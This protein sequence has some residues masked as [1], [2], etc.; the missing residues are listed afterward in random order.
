MYGTALQDPR[1]VPSIK[2]RN[3]PSDRLWSI[4]QQIVAKN[5]VLLARLLDDP[6][7]VA[8]NSYHWSFVNALMPSQSPGDVFIH[9]VEEQPLANNRQQHCFW[10]PFRGVDELIEFNGGQK[11]VLCALIFLPAPWSGRVGG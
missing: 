11:A 5:P 9:L 1:V 6:A 8:R 10:V 2:E 7:R 3:R 4:K